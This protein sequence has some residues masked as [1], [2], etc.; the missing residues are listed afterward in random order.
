MLALGLGVWSNHAAT[1]GAAPPAN[2]TWNPLSTGTAPSSANYDFSGGNNTATRAR[3]T[4][5]ALLRGT[6]AKTSGS[7]GYLEITITADGNNAVGVAAASTATNTFVGGDSN[8]F[9]YYQAGQFLFGGGPTTGSPA[10]FGSNIIGVCIKANKL[11][12]SRQGVWQ[13]G[14]D[15]SAG[16][17]GIDISGFIGSGLYPAASTSGLSVFVLNTGGSAF[18]YPLPTGVSAW[19]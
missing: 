2:S 15:P 5:D 16:T 4:G 14:G 6:A 1:G 8:S 19:G 10:S 17:G 7:S 3:S 12:F 11:Y 13:D 9:G 18:N